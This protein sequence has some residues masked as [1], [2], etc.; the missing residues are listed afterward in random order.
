MSS[1]THEQVQSFGR[2]VPLVN[3]HSL[4]EVAPLAESFIRAGITAV[5]VTLR[6]EHGL[7]AITAFSQ[8]PQ[9]K[10]IAGTIVTP[11]QINQALQAGADLLVSP[12]A[13]DAMLEVNAPLV[14]GVATATEI[15][16][17]LA[18]GYQVLK[19]FPIHSLGGVAWLQAMAGPLPNASFMVTG[20]VAATDLQA[21]A[22]CPNVVAIGGSW[23]ASRQLIEQQ[24]WQQITNNCLQAMDTLCS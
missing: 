17:A 10:V 14:P 8:Y 16:H 23:L 4:A 20:G 2:L 18:H 3:I 24:A 13:T 11:V 7:A 19:A 22:R 1:L 15:M 6:T 9:L 21:Y 5:E 12:G